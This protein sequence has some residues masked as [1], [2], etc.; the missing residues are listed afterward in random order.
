MREAAPDYGLNLIFAT[1]RGDYL[2][3]VRV[4][5]KDRSGQEV[6]STLTDGPMLLA[7]LPPGSY[8]V[9]A[10]ANGK[11]V[12]REVSVPKNGHR[13]AILRLPAADSGG[14]P[15]A[16]LPHTDGGRI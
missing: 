9:Q 12:T 8:T 13:Q 7:A 11:T 16:A 10:S 2:A 14:A 4:T 1:A 6:F 3:N 5:V 15:P